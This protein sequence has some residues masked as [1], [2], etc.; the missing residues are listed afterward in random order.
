MRLK[1]R[2]YLK[3][4]GSVMLSDVLTACIGFMERTAGWDNILDASA[5]LP[6]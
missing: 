2:R 6:L 1:L 5:A 4:R 3:R